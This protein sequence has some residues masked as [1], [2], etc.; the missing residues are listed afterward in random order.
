MVSSPK[1]AR[2]RDWAVVWLLPACYLFLVG[3]IFTIQRDLMYFPPV[4]VKDE[5]LESQYEKL[6][7]TTQDGLKISGYF[8]RPQDAAKPLIVL[9][10][11]NGSHPGWEVFK[12]APMRQQGYGVLLAEYRGFGGNPGKPTEEGLYQDG[13]AYLDWVR[14]QYPDNK[15]ILYGAS[16]GSGV[17]VELGQHYDPAAVILEVPFRS[18][19]DIARR[20]YWYVP[21]KNLFMVD[22]YRSDLKIKN[23]N[24]PILFLIAEHDEVVSAQS[25]QELYELANEPKEIMLLPGAGHNTA[26]N[27][28]AGKTV[29]AFLEGIFKP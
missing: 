28:G 26:Y 18:A 2:K 13:R 14:Q 15:L 29:T 11:G 24:A 20:F 6:T 23:I 25:G 27:F 21:L 4:D 16:L 10:H 3:Y 8:S 17:A 5:I 22:Q 19:L 9:F 1:P 12:T 7:V